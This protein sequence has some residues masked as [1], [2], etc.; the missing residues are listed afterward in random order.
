MNFF[1]VGPP[2]PPS[3]APRVSVVKDVVTV[4]WD[5]SENSGSKNIDGYAVEYS[6]VDSQKWERENC[7]SNSLTHTVKGLQKGQRY[8]FRVRACN[9]H[10]F[11]ESSQVSNIVEIEEHGKYVVL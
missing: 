2:K 1:V 11:S 10:G 5:P 7:D 6:V 9:L 4:T 8:I 3:E